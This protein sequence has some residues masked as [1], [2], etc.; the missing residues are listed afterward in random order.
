MHL[1]PYIEGAAGRH[2]LATA[3]IVLGIDYLFRKP[4]TP[5]N[6]GLPYRTEQELIDAQTA[7][8]LPA[9]H[10]DLPYTSLIRRQAEAMGETG[11]LFI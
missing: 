8:L 11:E 9:C 7:A 4:H 3:A 5:L 10:D 2:P 1:I 6:C